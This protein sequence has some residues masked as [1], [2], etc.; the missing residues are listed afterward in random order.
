MAAGGYGPILAAKTWPNWC[1]FCERSEFNKGAS[2]FRSWGGL[3]PAPFAE[4]D[5]AL[6]PTLCHHGVSAEARVLR[7]KW[8]HGMAV[9]IRKVSGYGS[10][11][12]QVTG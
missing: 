5:P 3:S 1:G 10:I 9:E 2:G 7:L 8:I 4:P 11:A 12:G 6:L